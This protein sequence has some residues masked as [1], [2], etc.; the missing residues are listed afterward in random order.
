MDLCVRLGYRAIYRLSRLWW[1]VRRPRHQGALV[2]IW[3]GE[4]LLLLRQSYQPLAAFPGGGVRAGEDPAAA[5]RR[6]L[7]EELRLRPE[8]GDLRPVFTTTQLWDGRLDT[9]AFFEWHL[10]TEPDLVPDHREILTAAF[11]APDQMPRR[12][13]APVAH[14]LLWRA[15]RPAA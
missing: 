3:V 14:Y 4:R 9:V 1:R 13:S 11:V 10:D 7:G 2:A 5:A 8:P 12:V 6:E 15:T